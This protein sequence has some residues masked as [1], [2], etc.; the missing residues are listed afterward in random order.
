MLTNDPV[1]VAYWIMSF[2]FPAM[3]LVY[4]LMFLEGR[5]RP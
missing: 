3:G 2:A 4:F 5:M 1:A